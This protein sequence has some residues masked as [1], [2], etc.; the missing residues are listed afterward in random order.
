MFTSIGTQS[1][2]WLQPP[3]QPAGGELREYQLKGLRWM[4]G[5]RRH[6]LNGILADEVGNLPP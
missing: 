3:P 5:L 2:R 4:V 6:G 1:P